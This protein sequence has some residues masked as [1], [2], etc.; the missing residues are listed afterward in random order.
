[1]SRE[2]RSYRKRHKG[3][4]NMHITVQ[5]DPYYEDLF[6]KTM[7]KYKLK[8]TML[9]TVKKEFRFED[10]RFYQDFHVYEV[11]DLP[12][13]E[14][15]VVKRFDHK[16]RI[17]FSFLPDNS[18]N[19]A[20][21]NNCHCDLCNSSRYRVFTYL[22]RHKE[23]GKYMQVG[24]N[25]IDKIFPHFPQF[26]NYCQFLTI[27]D[28][29]EEDRENLQPTAASSLPAKDVLTKAVALFKYF[30]NDYKRV[31]E[32]FDPLQHYKFLS[33]KD[34]QAADPIAEKIMQYIINFAGNNDYINNLKGI[35]E[36]NFVTIRNCRLWASAV[37]LIKNLN[38]SEEYNSIALQ[39][40]K[41]VLNIVKHI[42]TTVRENYQYTVTKM[43]LL[44]D[45]NNYVVLNI[46]DSDLEENIL[47]LLDTGNTAQVQVTCKGSS[48]FN[49]IVYNYCQ[50]AKLLNKP[51]KIQPE[52]VSHNAAYAGLD[53]FWQAVNS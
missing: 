33:D 20:R 44:T 7:K 19:E 38:R 35:A 41:Q 8:Y 6:A 22:L 26:D 15:E 27:K 3:G 37:T 25:C 39:E 4:H 14:W 13:S 31:K 9:E 36:S 53:Q 47:N 17:A 10:A 51:E 49:D 45:N 12:E 42:K 21:L 18:D 5:A 34:Y 32:V 11:E 48:V 50:R 30:D 24:S 23:T 29:F 46:S 16:D 52:T 1:M 40:G 28:S 43:H 2:K